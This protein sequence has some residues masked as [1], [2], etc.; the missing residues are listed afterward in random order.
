MEIG[1]NSGKYRPALGY[2]GGPF[3][4]RA[5]LHQKDLGIMSYFLQ[6]QGPE[7]EACSR[8]GHVSSLKSNRRVLR[9]PRV[10]YTPTCRY[11]SHNAVW[12]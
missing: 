7:N 12:N 8:G 10:D 4:Q 1:Q 5:E 11:S 9:V 6:I 3:Q 2:T